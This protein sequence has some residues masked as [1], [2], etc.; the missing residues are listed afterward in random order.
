MNKYLKPKSVS[1]WASVVPL[2]A[3]LAVA[4]LPL[5]GVHAVVD[6]INNITGGVSSALLINGGLAG[7]GFRGALEK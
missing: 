5:H 3:G 4:T 6:A 7:I 1:W 2:L